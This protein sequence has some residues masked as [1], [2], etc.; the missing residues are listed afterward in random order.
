[1]YRARHSLPVS[2][3]VGRWTVLAVGGWLLYG[4][5]YGLARLIWLGA[6]FYDWQWYLPVIFMA[7]F[8]LLWALRRLRLARGALALPIG[9]VLWLI[10]GFAGFGQ[11]TELRPSDQPPAPISFWAFTDFSNAPASLLEDL[12]RAGGR[13][14]L[15]AG[16]PDPATETGQ[17]WFAGVR[18]LAQH[19]IDVVVVVTAGDFLSVPVHQAWIENTRR[20]IDNIELAGLSNV[21]GYLGDAERPLNASYDVLGLE[22]GAF[23]AAQ[24]NLRT[25]QANLSQA[26]PTVRLGVTA[27]W[28]WYLDRL[29]GDAD[30]ALV[31]RSPMDP[32]SGWHFRTVMSY[33]SYLPAAD[34]AYY[35]FLV[36]RALARL[37]PT[38]RPGHLIGLVGAGFP[39][40]PLLLYEELVRD[41]RLSRA[42]GAPEIAVFQ[43]GALD[44]FGA[45]FVS[46]LVADV[47]EAPPETEVLI[48][49]S[50]LASAYLFIVCAADGWLDLIGSRL[51]LWIVWLIASG[52]WVRR[53]ATQ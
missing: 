13:L 51:W 47:N 11:I 37:F 3:I 4:L 5:N 19:D 41:A 32:P 25:F 15:D 8:P 9:L 27:H 34:R 48:P 39:W 12:Q 17:R 18:R 50:R 38:D 42:L 10:L 2:S 40:E 24:S 28:A 16:V 36:E 21:A 33:S 52:W 53:Q 46:R 49:F 35:L 30:L 26:A 44:T 14:Y 23:T 31:Q 20:A 43:L 7:V 1:M 45:D 29:D 6:P 22:R